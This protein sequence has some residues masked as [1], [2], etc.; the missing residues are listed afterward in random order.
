MGTPSGEESVTFIK[1]GLYVCWLIVGVISSI[2]E[3]MSVISCGFFG[4]GLD[5]TELKIEEFKKWDD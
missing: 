1:S 5:L 4:K 2:I 3:S